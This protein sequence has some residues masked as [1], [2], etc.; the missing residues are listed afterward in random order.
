MKIKSLIIVILILLAG[1]GVFYIGKAYGAGESS[2]GTSGDPLITKSYLEE[3]LAGVGEPVRG[4]KRV[5][6]N[7]GDALYADRGSEI[8]IYRGNAAV[9]GEGGL[10]N[11]SKG[12]LFKEGDT[13]VKYNIFLA[14]DDGCGI[15]ASGK[16]I[17]F[18][19]GSYSK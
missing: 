12:V 14:P 4:F 16:V 10:I 18:V 17:V 7:K 15:I 6:L 1:T 13:A 2:P 19:S 11:L 5:V 9:K 8:V 3:R